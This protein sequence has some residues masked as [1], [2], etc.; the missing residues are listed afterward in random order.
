MTLSVRPAE[1]ED[2]HF[3]VN[4]VITS[5][6]MSMTAANLVPMESYR[7]VMWPA[8]E[9]IMA[10]PNVRSVVAYETTETDR[11][12][13]LYGFILADTVLHPALV[14]YVF[15]ASPYRRAGIA[16]RLFEAIGVDPRKPFSMA[17]TTEWTH[18]LQH[19]IPMAKY[20]PI[21]AR[22]GKEAPDADRAEQDHAR[23][24]R[25]RS[26]VRAVPTETR[27]ARAD[28]A[29]PVQGADGHPRK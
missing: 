13:D 7:A 27:R 15:V 16:R 4:G 8:I 18:R 25:R 2:R 6:R 12:A 19:K 22:F 17:A 3:I 24:T 21:L 23:K 10:R 9:A 1:D 20:R 29:A 28:A 26:M 14:Y 11:I 5:Y